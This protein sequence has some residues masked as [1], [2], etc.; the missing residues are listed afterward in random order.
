MKDR[1]STAFRTQAKEKTGISDE[2]Y[3]HEIKHTA[4]LGEMLTFK[5]DGR[6]K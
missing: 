2:S 4:T 6:G 5:D 1:E 3:K